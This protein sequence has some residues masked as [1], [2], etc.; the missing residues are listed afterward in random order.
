MVI[1]GKQSFSLSNKGEISSPKPLVGS[2][3]MALCCAND[4]FY[5]GE[6]RSN[7]QRSPVHVWMW[8]KGQEGWSSVWQFE[9]IRHVHGIYHD[10]YTGAIW[11]TTGDRNSEAA[12]WRTDDSFTTLKKITGGSQQCRA[13]QLLFSSS[14]VYFGSDT[15]NE[16]NHI[17]R[18][19]RKGEKIECLAD[20]NSSIFYG[21][22]VGDSLF[23]S[24]AVEPSSVNST[25]CAAVWRSDNGEDWENIIELKKDLWSMKYFQYGQV[26]FPAGPGDAKHLYYSP[27][28]TKGHGRTFVLDI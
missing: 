27:F 21:C 3:P 2:R 7:K 12:I 23:F 9:G 5:Y 20:V 14:H 10:P 22:K 17:Y 6:Y 25:P 24:T 15:P 19:N 18:M 26:L 8:C 28:A 1:A 11:V 4:R 13:V 16:K